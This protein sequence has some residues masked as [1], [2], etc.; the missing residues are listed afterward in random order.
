M[1]IPSLYLSRY[2]FIQYS[3]SIVLKLLD[4]PAT[5]VRPG[6][7]PPSKLPLNAMLSIGKSVGIDSLALKNDDLDKT[8]AP[9][10]LPDLSIFSKRLI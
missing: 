2:A 6:N 9:F 3:E 8:E 1:A 5:T 7:S 4:A 10:I